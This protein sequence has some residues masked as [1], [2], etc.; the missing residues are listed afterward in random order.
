[1]INM[2]DIENTS[3]EIYKKIMSELSDRSLL[4]EYYSLDALL[5]P[6]LIILGTVLLIYSFTTFNITSEYFK[7]HIEP[8]LLIISIIGVLYIIWKERNNIK[9]V[10]RKE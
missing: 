10:W 7:S 8:I 3:S 6:T 4:E 9:K 1:M 5:F 2:N